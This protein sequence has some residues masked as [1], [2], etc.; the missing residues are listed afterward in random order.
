MRHSLTY[1]ILKATTVQGLTIPHKYYNKI[2]LIKHSADVDDEAEIGT[3]SVYLFHVIHYGVLVHWRY[4]IGILVAVSVMAAAAESSER[5]D[6]C[7]YA[8]V[9]WGLG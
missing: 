7:W 5:I 8:T 1:L 6:Y 2:N 4:Y 3:I 9:R